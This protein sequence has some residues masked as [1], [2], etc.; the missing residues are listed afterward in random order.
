MTQPQGPTDQA[1]GSP[2]PPPPP[3]GSYPPPGVAATPGAPYQPTPGKAKKPIY[4]KW[5]FW[6]AVGAVALT[7]AG[8]TI[9]VNAA[10]DTVL[11]AGTLGTHDQ[12]Y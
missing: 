8:T 3:P 2:P 9:Y 6:T 5:W 12:R 1:G 11:P 7:A 4:K 10:R